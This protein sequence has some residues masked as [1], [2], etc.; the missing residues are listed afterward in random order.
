MRN[1]HRHAFLIASLWLTAISMAS[2]AE[3]LAKDQFDQLRAVIEPGP[4][5]DHWADIG[6]RTNLWTGR[7]QEPADAT[8]PRPGRDRCPL[9]RAA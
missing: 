1:H 6:W 4:G 7:P 2:G 9:A 5:E 3:P 8:P